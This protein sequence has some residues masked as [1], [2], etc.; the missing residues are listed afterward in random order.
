M[1]KQLRDDLFGNLLSNLKLKT[2][3]VNYQKI[4]QLPLSLVR[5]CASCLLLFCEAGAEEQCWLDPDALWCMESIEV[6]NEVECTATSMVG[7]S[8]VVHKVA[9]SSSETVAFLFL[10]SALAHQIFAL[11]I[12]WALCRLR[13]GDASVIPEYVQPEFWLVCWGRETCNKCWGGRF[14]LNGGRKTLH[15]FWSSATDSACLNVEA[16]LRCRVLFLGHV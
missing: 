9:G 8:S 10:I 7:L 11:N 12:C 15:Y 5:A 4:I 6:G 2:L 14:L 13:L 1:W 16:N 3:S